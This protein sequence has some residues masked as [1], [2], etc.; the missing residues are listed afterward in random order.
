V[1]RVRNKQQ[2]FFVASTQCLPSLFAIFDTI[3]IKDGKWILKDASRSFESDAVLTKVVLR[4]R[5]IPIEEDAHTKTLLHNRTHTERA[6]TVALPTQT[7]SFPLLRFAGGGL[8]ASCVTKRQ[9]S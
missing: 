1:C 5:I 9:C 6:S 8:W 3:L 7:S 4:F 2:M